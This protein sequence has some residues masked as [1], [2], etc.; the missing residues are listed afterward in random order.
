MLHHEYPHFHIKNQPELQVSPFISLTQIPYSREQLKFWLNQ[1]PRKLIL[2][3][4]KEHI[5]NIF[6]Y[7]FFLL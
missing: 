5:K 4:D 7:Q 6:I 3:S 2:D 1:K